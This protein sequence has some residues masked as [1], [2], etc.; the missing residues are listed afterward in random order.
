MSAYERILYEMQSYYM[1][2]K[3]KKSRDY[4]K[5]YLDALAVITGLHEK[6]V[7]K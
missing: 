5:G 7:L 2:F 6:G 4:D 3:E 1:E